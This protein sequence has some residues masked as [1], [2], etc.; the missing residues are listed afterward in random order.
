MEHVLVKV[1]GDLC[2]VNDTLANALLREQPDQTSGEP[3]LTRHTD[4]LL[5]SFEG[6]FYPMEEVLHLVR[7]AL[8]PELEGKI[9]YIDMEAWILTRYIVSGGF[10][11][12]TTRSLNHVMAYSGF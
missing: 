6:T 12:C 3:A 1:Y 2:P 4:M 8:T 11:H 9:D 10:I 5:F 7:A